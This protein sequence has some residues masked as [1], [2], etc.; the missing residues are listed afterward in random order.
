M[1]KTPYGGAADSAL[2]RITNEAGLGIYHI[3]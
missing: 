2:A 1:D 3:H